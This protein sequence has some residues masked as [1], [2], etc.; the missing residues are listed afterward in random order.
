MQNPLKLLM[1]PKSIAMVGAGANPM[2]IGNMFAMGISN[3]G[4]KG[5]FYPVHPKA[6]IVSGHKAY[7]SVFDLPE[8]PDLAVFIVPAD[9]VIKYLEDFGRFGTK[10]AIII[11]AGFREVGSE[12]EKKE[13][14]LNEIAKKY[15]IRFIG[16]N[17]MGII[18][19]EISLNAT[20]M[21]M[22]VDSG[23]LGFIS[24]SGT[25]VAQVLPYLEKKGIR[26]SKSISI[27][28]GTSIDICDALEYMGQDEQTKAIAIYIEGLSDG[29]KF[30]EIAQKITPYKPVIAQYVGGSGAGASAG[31]SHTGSLAGPDYLYEGIF[32]Q[33]GIIRVQSVEELYD[34]GWALAT[35]P[36]IRGKRVGII[37]NSGGP[38][39]AI[40]DTCNKAGMVIPELSVKLQKSLKEVL[41]AQ[42]S[43]KNPIDLT[44]VMDSSLLASKI[45]NMLVQSGE[46]DA[47]AIHGIIGTGIIKTMY[48]AIKKSLGDISLDAILEGFDMDLTDVLNIKNKY[49]LPLFISSFFDRDDSCTSY[50]QDN[51]I[52][53]YNSPEKAAKA[54]VVLYQYGEIKKREKIKA[55]TLLEQNKESVK[56]IKDAI[57]KGSKALNEYDAKKILSLYDIPVTKEVLTYSIDD[58]FDA[59]DQIGYPVVIKGC[60]SDILHKTGKGLICLNIKNRDE[61]SKSFKSI[62]ESAKRDIPVLIQE[63]V[64][65][66][67]EFLAGMTR[68]SGFGPCILFGIGGIFAEAINDTTL[69]SAPLSLVEAKEMICN[70]KADKILNAF[71][72][73]EPVNIK[74]LAGIL[75][76]LSMISILHPEI[77]EIDL[78]P[79]IINKSN[80]VVVDALLVLGE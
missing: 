19:S 46:V 7:K 54:I 18:N 44:L 25:Y 57:G 59:A 17:C 68:F 48:P 39:T 73:M 41:P 66:K 35:Q 56:I 26:Y 1:S 29:R 36:E 38:G 75:Q 70:I 76:K 37:T 33:A 21:P 61:L 14:M 42:G 8:V 51:D 62:R 69:R 77:S 27:G 58:A 52:P 9:I 34:F 32:K 50:F 47:I 28:N 55:L 30:I 80:P 72:G 11:T 67:R 74:S 43:S 4:F 2:K 24:Q 60:S 12:G 71:R 20:V 16:P 63:M 22:S 15:G 5:N 79:I 53:V 45:P 49:D 6:E 3:C 23:G 78:N 10:R 64:L 65:G 40:S 31:L 13:A